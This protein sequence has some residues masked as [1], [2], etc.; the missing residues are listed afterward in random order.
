MS[1]FKKGPKRPSAQVISLGE[2]RSSRAYQQLLTQLQAA[3]ENIPD[4]E[5]WSLD[6]FFGGSPSDQEM[7]V[8]QLAY[9][10]WLVFDYRTW[11]DGST[12]LDRF[13]A[14]AK[15]DDTSREMLNAWRTTRL[16]VYTIELPFGGATLLRDAFTGAEF[17]V[18]SD[19]DVEPLPAGDL[20]ICRILPVGDS[21]HLGYDVRT[22]AA[23]PLPLVREA[24]ER[25]LLR[26]R[27]QLP[28]AA[29]DDLFK[30]RWPLVHD[31]I[32]NALAAGSAIPLPDWRTP[33]S[34]GQKPPGA[35]RL[36]TEVADQLWQFLTE[37]DVS[38]ADRQ[39]AARLWWDAVAVLKPAAG[40]A[41][42]WAAGAAYAHLRYA[43]ADGTTQAEIAEMFGISSSTLAAKSRAIVEAV[44]LEELDDRYAD[45]LD[46]RVRFR[47]AP[48]P[49]A[50]RAVAAA[51]APPD[52]PASDEGRAARQLLA[53]QPD[54]VATLALVGQSC[55]ASGTK[56]QAKAYAEQAKSAYLQRRAEAGAGRR[57]GLLRLVE[58]LAELSDD[59]GILAVT[60]GEYPTDL[61]GSVLRRGAIAL[62]RV[63][64]AA[65]AGTWL[66]LAR[67]KGE[68]LNLVEPFIDAL[69]LMAAKRIPVYKLDYHEQLDSLL[70]WVPKLNALT[71]SH[72]ACA[73][74]FN[75]AK[76]AVQ[77]VRAVGAQRDPWAGR[78]LQ[79]LFKQDDLPR[80]VQD[81]IEKALNRRTR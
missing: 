20:A 67:T 16:G 69:Q 58:F 27:R 70:G 37:D 39:R 23:S 61:D 65:E 57:D 13:A 74:F 4:D 8:L 1:P 34:Q 15:L 50:V 54:D 31:A 43:L 3:C 45:P 49:L 75:K 12:M 71:R 42:A 66:D 6:Q 78:L 63:G 62:T 35:N 36:Q 51:A 80:T 47:A 81:A 52:A 44:G 21:F 76:D 38:Y 2:V 46:P 19:P 53:L 26:M 22:T 59:E 72:L 33:P 56:K 55:L 79:H 7:D 29:F 11:E 28:G 5:P 24:V 32:T 10:D 41:D 68:P 64:R 25:E 14:D 40:G 30:E 17:A 18:Q 9:L 60:A 73:I 48:E 77:A